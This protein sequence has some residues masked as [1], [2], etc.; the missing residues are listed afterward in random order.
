MLQMEKFVL[1][2]LTE[3]RVSSACEIVKA[4]LQDRIKHFFQEGRRS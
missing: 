3:N 2:I 1:K 4:E